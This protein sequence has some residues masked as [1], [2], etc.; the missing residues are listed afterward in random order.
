LRSPGA[1]TGGVMSERDMWAAVV[2]QAA[3]DIE[4]E[5][6]GSVEYDDA[7]AFFTGRGQWLESRRAV[8]DHCGLHADDIERLGRIAIESR[9]ERDPPPAPVIPPR[10][11]AA[12]TAYTPPIARP[13]DALSVKRPN[14]PRRA[15]EKRDRTWW[16]ARF[17]AKQAA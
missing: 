15:G 4:V 11:V 1:E 16:I 6:R 12:A 13:A 5:P 9:A 3:D 14:S 7:V 8:A 10:L 17:M 2:L